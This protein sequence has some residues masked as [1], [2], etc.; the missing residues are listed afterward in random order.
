MLEYFA[1][2]NELHLHVKGDLTKMKN[3][4]VVSSKLDSNYFLVVG[5]KYCYYVDIILP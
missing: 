5:L 2:F 3:E 1:I 4:E